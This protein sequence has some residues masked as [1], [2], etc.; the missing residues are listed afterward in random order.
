MTA[1]YVVAVAPSYLIPDDACT[2]LSDYSALGLD[3]AV[4]AARRSTPQQLRTIVEQSGLRSRDHAALSVGR[5]WVQ[6]CRTTDVG[7]RYL[8]ATATDPEPGSFSDRHLL[9]TN[10]F[11]VIEGIVTA[12]LALDTSEAFIVMRRSFEREYEI[13]TTALAEAETAGWLEQVSIKCVRADDHYLL[14]DERSVLE[15]IEGRAPIPR[16]LSPDVDGL[17]CNA[18]RGPDGVERLPDLPNATVVETIETLANVAAIVVN[19]SRWF[20]TIGTAVS[21]GNL[22]CTITGDVNTHGVVEAELGERLYDVIEAGGDGYLS[23]SSPKAV[24]SGVSSA[25][26]TRSRLSAPMSWEGLAAVGADIGRAAFTVHDEPTN[27]IEVAHRVAAYL[28]VESCGLCPPCK[29]GGGEVTAYLARLAAGVGD[30]R[31]VEALNQRVTTVADGRR[32]DIPLRMYKIVSSIMQAFPGDVRD[33]AHRQLT[34][35]TPSTLEHIVD[36]L[37]GVAIHGDTQARRRADWSTSS[38]PVELTRW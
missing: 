9:R 8:V 16:R 35:V 4:Q 3:A 13:L 28:Y 7:T 18:E 20:R 25:V 33:A 32:C 14:N 11:A 23:A 15:V 34:P 31:D 21:P 10:P 17:F 37:G 38:T 5:R 12:A 2:S 29:Y 36:I 30:Q 6:I 27:M 1:G 22:L 19:G 24:L 26:L